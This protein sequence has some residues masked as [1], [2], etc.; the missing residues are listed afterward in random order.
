MGDWVR[1]NRKGN[2]SVMTLV[3]CNVGPVMMV[4]ALRDG[5]CYTADP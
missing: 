1:K 2:Q 3:L 4:S 5:I